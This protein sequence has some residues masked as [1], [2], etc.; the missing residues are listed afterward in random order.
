MHIRH[1][2]GAKHNRQPRQVL[3]ILENCSYPRDA[4]VGKQAKTLIEAGYQVSVISPDSITLPGRVLMDGVSFYRFP[5]IPFSHGTLGYFLEY[6][7]AMFAITALTAYALFTEGFDIVHIANPPDCIILVT[8]IYKLIGKRIIYDQHDLCP[9]LY[10][11]KF[12]RPNPLLLR[13]Q[14][15]L[16][17]LS[18]KLADHTIVTNES[19]KK[20]AIG[21][22]R[23]I[24]VGCHCGTEWPRDRTPAGA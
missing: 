6:T 20:I 23:S 22:W 4:R 5:R 11:N 14:L 24:T 19:H 21:P 13:V 16:E 15:L 8:A 7:Y 17:R 12:P 10:V 1:T 9:E 18:Y 2:A 3:M